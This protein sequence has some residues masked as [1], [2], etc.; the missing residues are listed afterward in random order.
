MELLL[1]LFGGLFGLKALWTKIDGYKTYIAGA[2]L[3]LGGAASILTGLAGLLAEFLPLQGIPQVY[4]WLK[5]MGH[6][7]NAGIVTAG[8]IA[9]HQGLAAVGQRCALDKV[10]AA[11]AAT[12]ALAVPAPVQ[13][14]EN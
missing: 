9:F 6:D 5:G 4:T 7:V 14:P 10:D 13:P 12:V 1:K 11:T 2:S 8:W 3:M